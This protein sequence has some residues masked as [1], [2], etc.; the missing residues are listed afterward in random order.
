MIYGRTRFSL[1]ITVLL[2][3]VFPVFAKE[4]QATD[5]TED[6]MSAM[7]RIATKV[8]EALEERGLNI[9]EALTAAGVQATRDGDCINQPSCGGSGFHEGPRG[10]QA[11]TSIA[12][13]SSGV[14]IVVGFNDTRG[15]SL[16]PVSVSGFMYSDDG[17]ATFVDGGQL[18]TPGNDTIGTT[19]YPQVFGDPEVKYLGAC[20][21]IYSS[22]MVKKFSS[23]PAPGRTVQTM[24]VHRSSDCGHTWTGP[25][26]V[27][28]ATNPNGALNAQGSPR[29]AADKE[30]MDVDPETGR[31][32]LSWSNFT[33]FAAGGVEIAT[34]FSD[35]AL[36][37]NP[38][39]WSARKIVAATV[40]DGQSSVP[41]FAGDSAN[42]YVTWRRF[43]S[44]FGNIIGF[45]RSTDNGT[46]WGSPVNTSAE[47][48]TMDQVLGNDRVNTSPS[49]AVDN[50]GG[51]FQGNIYLVY[52]NNNFQDGA[53]IAFQRSTNGGMTFSTPVRL[54]SRLGDDRAQWFPWVTV[55]KTT[56][57][58]HVFY[59]DQGVASS[60][61]LSQV[62]HT[63]SDDGGV[64]W[65]QPLPLT[66]RPFKAGWGNDTGQPNLGDYNQAVAQG[67]ELFAVFAS[68]ELAGFQDGQPSS[69]S[70]NT[71]DVTFKRLA[72]NTHKF[73]ATTL[74]LQNVSFSESG[75]N[76][77]LDPGDTANLTLT[78]RNYVTNPLNADKVRGINTSLSTSTPGVVVLQGLSEYPNINPG[79]SANNLSNFVIQL[80][81]AFVPGTHIELALD[82]KS[83]EQ[84]SIA[85][86]HTLATGTPSA[87][88][89][90]AENFNGVAPGS[91]PA[92]WTTAHGGGANEVKW[93]TNTSFCGTSSNGAFHINANDGPTGGSPVR[94]ERLFSPQIIVPADAEYV[95]VD[96]EV[97]YDSE[98]DPNFNILAY[99]G[100]LLRVTDLT[101]GRFLRSVLAE[102]F[103]EEFTTGSLQ[104]YP[105]HFPRSSNANYFQDMSA[106]AGDSNG[107]KHV[108]MKFPGAVGAS[109]GIAGSAIQLR[110]EFT[111]DGSATCA[112]V[113][114]GH[115][116]GVMFDNLVVNSV[117]SVQP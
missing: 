88:T 75:A 65:K 40:D 115:S 98:D 114:P 54:N 43:P 107:F 26:E 69:A 9:N 105:K 8:R 47:F 32:L 20:N 24:S 48:F 12:V 72:E 59:Y 112:D 41:R 63:F 37:G 71:P 34:T 111:Q 23:T 15:F 96:F 95:T 103:E 89:L 86:L 113:R 101:P 17:G 56:G 25:F 84:G 91:L 31:V 73:K 5:K 116:C 80:T 64:N 16:N 45:A 44:A 42:A 99:D 77:N 85:L 78:L 79:A 68:T 14:H 94:F 104:H 57:R 55:D 7:G 1:L 29:D 2:L 61:D 90:L 13:D 60:G 110:F 106:W 6:Q 53:D 87:T 83:A 76:G 10:G 36:S 81:P 35:D 52:A 19:R 3:L 27:T 93:T 4:K 62:S 102:A 22:I 30:F 74:D 100:F 39:T 108:R 49:L 38:P 109:A 70:M 21:F 33:P 82:I 97:C 50:S 11:E 117:K 92:G 51:A 66:D 58:I 18:P 46:T 67:G 28:S